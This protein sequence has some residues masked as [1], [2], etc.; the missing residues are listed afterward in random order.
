MRPPILFLSIA[1]CVGL[2]FGLDVSQ[3]RSAWYVVVPVLGTALL[4]ARPAPLGAALGV[5]GVAGTIWGVAAV[6]E[7]GATCAGRGARAAIVRLLDPVAA[8]GGVV[9]ADVQP[10]WCGGALRLRWPE[11][12]PARG[13]TEWVVAGRWSGAGERAVLVVRRTVQLDAVPRGR[14]ALRDRLSAR[15]AALFGARASIVDALV[16]SPNE[17]LDPDIRER[18][19]RSGLAH[20]LSISGLH[21]GFLAAWL[22][23][24]LRK[25]R[26]APLTRFAATLV[27][28]FGYLWLLG[29]PPP[30]LRAGAM[31][32]LA[33]LARL[34]QRVVAPRGVVALS[35]LAVLLVDPW[36]LHSVGAWL[37]VAGI[38]AVVW[39]DR[40]FARAK[41]LVRLCAPA[42]AATLLTAP[43]SALVFGTVAPIGVVANLIAIPVASVAVPG[44]VLALGLSW[45]VTGLAHLV[46]AG[47]GLGLALLD[48]AARGAAAVPGGHVVMIAGW[49]AAA[50]WAAI[51]GVA[52]WLWHSPRRPWL[53]GAPRLC[54]HGLR[55]DVFARRRSPRRLHLLDGIFSRR[56]ARGRSC[57]ADP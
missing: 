19:V 53:I 27:L 2:W 1:F 26:L 51:A 49:E 23:L 30:A 43:I 20:I 6:R 15:S 12:H 18:Y 3:V 55:R 24:L 11:D 8:R 7:R 22:A 39:A 4:V 41:R 44:L 36:A 45:L 40:A 32:V 54:D 57:V 34:C 28:L 13:G 46:A 33:E 52:W 38:T 31:L 17:Q 50:L 16:F 25:L 29:L 10:G 14:G 35:A 5:M 48:L 9:D 56:G 47:A 37:S 21:V 42:V